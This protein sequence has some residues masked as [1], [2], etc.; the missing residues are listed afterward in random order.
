MR[1]FNALGAGLFVMAA[2]AGAGCG[3]S[4]AFSGRIVVDDNNKEALTMKSQGSLD[5]D[6][7][8][9][10]WV[11][12]RD[13]SFVKVTGRA[14]NNDTAGHHTVRMRALV[15]NENH[16]RLGGNTAILYPTYLGPGQSGDFEFTFTYDGAPPKEL[17]LQ[18][19]FVSPR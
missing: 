14:R 12:A 1:L 11:S 19:T 9:F 5:F 3:A 17:R 10:Q 4:P 16:K 18:C 13:S 2:L 15:F 7:T 6:V 8:E